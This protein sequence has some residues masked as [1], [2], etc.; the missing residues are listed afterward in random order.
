MDNLS[1]RQKQLKVAISTGTDGDNVRSRNAILQH[2]FA[3]IVDVQ[4]K[5]VSITYCGKI[6]VS[7]LCVTIIT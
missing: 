5:G 4:V 3:W 7:L 6:L 1:T 2:P